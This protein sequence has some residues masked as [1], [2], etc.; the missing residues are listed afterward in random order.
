MEYDVFISYSRRDTAVADRICAAFDRAGITYF[1]DRQGIGGGMEFPRVLAEAILGCRKFLFLASAH[2]YVSKFTNSEI[3]FAFNKKE[4]DSILPYRID[5]SRMPLDLEFVF[6][7]INWRNIGEHPIEPVLVNDLLNMLG[8]EPLRT[9][10]GEPAPLPDS[11]P[12]ASAQPGI[13]RVG[14]LYR[15]NGREGIVFEVDATGRHGKILA[16][17][18]L[19]E[20]VAWCRDGTPAAETPTGAADEEDGM[21]NLRCIRKQSSPLTDF[22]AFAGC[23]ALGEGWYLPA[24][25]EL[26]TMHARQVELSLAAERGGGEAFRAGSYRASTESGARMAWGINFS[27]GFAGSDLNKTWKWWVR[28]VAAF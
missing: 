24:I 14:D 4:R 10:P 6:C 13:Y 12:G 23:A 18:D 25:G 9:R 26:K 3:T 11:V 15:Q 2:S 7:N 21:R 16:L 17:R 1:I 22:P 19:P 5:D 20:R 8:R 27:S 28:P